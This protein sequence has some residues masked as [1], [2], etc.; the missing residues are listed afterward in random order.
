MDGTRDY[1]TKWSKSDRGRQIS[2]DIAYMWNLKILCKWTYLQNRSRETN[3]ENKLTVPRREGINGRLGL[4]YT[5]SSV[6]SRSAVSDSLWPHGLEPAR[7]LHPWFFPGKN[8]GVGCHFLLQGIFPAQGLNPHLLHWQ[9]DSLPLSQL[10]SPAHT[11]I[12]TTDN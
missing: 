11:A 12:Y 7:L 1:N 10:G 4:T 6:H 2:L 5:L 9:A 8:T 3:V